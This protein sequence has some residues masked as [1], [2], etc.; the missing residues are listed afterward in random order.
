MKKNFVTD[1]DIVNYTLEVIRQMNVDLWTPEIVLG[2]S[3]GGLVPA[4]YISQWYDIPMFCINKG[5]FF[6][7]ELT[8]YNEILIIDDIND[9]GNTLLEF[10]TKYGENQGFKYAALIDNAGSKF[11][12]DYAGHYINKNEVPDWIV[13]PWEEWWKK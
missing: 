7:C 2:F 6:N 5:V 4:N 3:R 9:T 10:K 11:E 12:T 13:F 1:K 8:T